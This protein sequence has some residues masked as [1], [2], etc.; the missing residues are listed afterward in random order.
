MLI[1]RI[2]ISVSLIISMSCT[3]QQPA[4]STQN[5]NGGESNYS[6]SIERPK[7]VVGIVVDQMRYDYLTRFF[8]HYGEGGFKRMMQEGFDCR[9]NHYNY[10]PTYTGPGHAS[11]FTGTTP[12]YHGV[13]S[14]NWYDKEVKKN[15]DPTTRFMR[16]RLDKPASTQ[17]LTSFGL[18]INANVV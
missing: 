16:F 5:T 12:K 3:G 15:D 11:I 17:I 18:R 7:L 2:L 9:N 10:V 8:N 4:V 1:K 6:I 14:N 13:I